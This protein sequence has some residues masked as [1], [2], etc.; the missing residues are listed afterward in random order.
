MCSAA[1][2]RSSPGK[3]FDRYLQEQIFNP[4]D[5]HDTSFLV[6]E[7]KRDRVATIYR[8]GSAGRSLRCPKNYGSE[9]FFSGGGGL[10]STARDYTRFA[11]MLLNGGELDGA[12]ILKPETIAPMT[13]NQIGD[14]TPRSPWSRS[15]STGWASGWSWR[16]R[17]TAASPS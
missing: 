15:E 14:S 17:P 3:S 10:F 13:T 11:Q 7:A 5:M 9:T 4:L 16:R 1:W 2:S 12:R 6:P 8:A